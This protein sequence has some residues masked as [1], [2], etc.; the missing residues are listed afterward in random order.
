MPES[1]GQD[2]F[3]EVMPSLRAA[4]SAGARHMLVGVEAGLAECTR[5]EGRLARNVVL[6]SGDS[7]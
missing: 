7:M 6:H 5:L 4:W 2:L 3:E 1:G